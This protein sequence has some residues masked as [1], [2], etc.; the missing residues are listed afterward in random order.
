MAESQTTA[1]STSPTSSTIVSLP[2]EQSQIQ[3]T[4][5]TTSSTSSEIVLSTYTIIDSSTSPSTPSAASNLIVST[6]IGN[7]QQV[8]FN[9]DSAPSTFATST[10]PLATTS[11]PDLSLVDAQA[12]SVVSI[13]LAI[14]SPSSLINSG[15]SSIVSAPTTVAF[16]TAMPTILASGQQAKTTL[17]SNALKFSCTSASSLILLGLLTLIVL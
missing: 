6:P 1:I 4:S 7:Q 14:A 11:I 10:P 5:S 17:A 15:P 12:Q 3:S 9:T 16:E 13:P 8:S 2:A